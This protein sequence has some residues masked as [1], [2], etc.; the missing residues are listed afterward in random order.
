MTASWSEAAWDYIVV[1][2]GSAG[3][4][5]ADRLSRDPGRRVLLLEAGP[6]DASP[7]VHMPKGMGRLFGDARYVHVFP[8]EADEATPSESW[9]RGKLL[10]GSSS[11]NG[12]MYFRGQPQDYEIWAEAA[13]AE[14][15]WAAMRQA[16][17]AVEDHEQAGRPGATP[18]LG[19][20]K[21]VV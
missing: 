17:A 10:G 11:I 3:C 20:R 18:G 9:I 12:M 19:D 5:L 15:G 14:W 2:A 1:G 4:V 21:S 16:F 13:G 7:L 8:T 6:T